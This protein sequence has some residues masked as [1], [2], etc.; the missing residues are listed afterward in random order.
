MVSFGDRLRL[1]RKEMKLTQDEL[2]ETFHINK[3][4]ISRYENNCQL[5]EYDLLQKIADFFNV[6]LDYILGK[7]DIAN[8]NIHLDNIK[9]ILNHEPSCTKTFGDTLELLRLKNGWTQTELAKILSVAKGTVSNWENNNRFPD[10]NMLINLA[11]IFNVSID[12]LL[13]RTESDIV[14]HQIAKESK[15][16][17]TLFMED[18]K[19]LFMNGE[20]ADEDKEEIFKYV[21]DL[22]WESKKINKEK[23]S[24]KKEK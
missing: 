7:T 6:S 10:K 18:A 9:S 5:P 2:A 11:D 16:N 17:S 14:V 12:L 19:A 13:G 22:F 23:Y 20:V 1:L 24:R 3:S 4:S 8:I 21:S 15:N